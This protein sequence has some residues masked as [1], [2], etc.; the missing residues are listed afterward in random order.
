MEINLLVKSLAAQMPYDVK[1][2]IIDK[3]THFTLKVLKSPEKFD[4][5]FKKYYRERGVREIDIYNHEYRK[6]I[7]L[8]IVVRRYCFGD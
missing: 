6:L 7:D 5:Y 1:I 2:E 3:G 4:K 8:S